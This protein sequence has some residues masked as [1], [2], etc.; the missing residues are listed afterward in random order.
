[1]VEFYSPV[2]REKKNCKSCNDYV[3]RCPVKAIQ[4]DTRGTF[5]I[6]RKRC[7][8]YFVKNDECL[9]CLNACTFE[10]LAMDVFMIN[11]TGEI[12]RKTIG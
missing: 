2:I 7:A 9:E 5:T 11:K 4:R 8:E 12:A 3:N 1:M 6:E 10:A